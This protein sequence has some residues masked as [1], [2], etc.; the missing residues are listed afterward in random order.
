MDQ[1]YYSPPAGPTQPSNTVAIIS[2]IASILGLTFF[3]FLGSVLGLIL[4]YVARKQIRES[5]G[6]V[7]GEG[8][9]KW[10]IILGWIGVAL[11]VIV[12][13][14]GTLLVVLGIAVPSIGICANAGDLS[15]WNY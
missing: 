9:A 8:M 14:V 10:G 5:G 6:A 12:I 3:P 1:S 13:C 4:G 15:N 7:G 11:G 2:L